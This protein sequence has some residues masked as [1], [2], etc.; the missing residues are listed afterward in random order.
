MKYITFE[1]AFHKEIVL[2]TD[3]NDHAAVVERLGISLNDI[4]GA[5]FVSADEYNPAPR[6]TGKSVSLHTEADKGDTELLRRF[7]GWNKE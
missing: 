7:L 2:F 6:C 1:G 4:I 5:G 3:N